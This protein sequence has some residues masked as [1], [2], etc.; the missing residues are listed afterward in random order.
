M[1]STSFKTTSPWTSVGN[2]FDIS[3][4]SF[5]GFLQFIVMTSKLKSLSASRLIN[6]LRKTSWQNGHAPFDR[7][8]RPAR[9]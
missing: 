4:N 6:N 2:F 5:G 8:S 9:G 1:S 7:P 3:L